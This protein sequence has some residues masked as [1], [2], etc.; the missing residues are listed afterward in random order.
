MKKQ[1]LKDFLR[2][3]PASGQTR[4]ATCNHPKRTEVE[5]IVRDY[6]AMREA[7]ETRFP[8]QTLVDEFIK[9]QTG[10]DL[11]PQSLVR[12]VRSCLGIKL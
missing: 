4:C 5:R 9:K 6:V 7:G 10:Y 1:S 8:F 11:L 3:K 12:H 2:S